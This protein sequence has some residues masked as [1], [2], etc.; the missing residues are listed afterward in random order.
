MLIKH[1]A[2]LSNLLQSVEDHTRGVLR[3]YG[4]HIWFVSYNWYIVLL[5]SM[6]CILLFFTAQV[7]GCGQAAHRKQIRTDVLYM[8]YWFTWYIDVFYM[9]CIDVYF[10]LYVLM[11]F[12]WYIEVFYVMYW[13]ISRDILMYLSWYIF[14]LFSFS[15]L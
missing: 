5:I 10:T 14:F 2:K 9:K 8:I 1:F 4:L 6:P 7:K 11:Y 3:F 15:Y 13:C 12:T